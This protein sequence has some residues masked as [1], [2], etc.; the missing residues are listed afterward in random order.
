MAAQ[1]GANGVEKKKRSKKRRTR[2]EGAISV[3][4]E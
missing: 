2:T 4:S 1:R 3:L